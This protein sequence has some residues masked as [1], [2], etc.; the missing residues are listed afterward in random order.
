M[1]NEK[2]GD[3]IRE[4]TVHHSINGDFTIRKGEWK[5]LLSP[6]SGGWSFPKP[7]TDD[8]VIETLPLI[9]LYNMKTD[10]A[11]KNNV[12]AEHPEVVKELKDLMIKYVKEGR[13]TP[14]APQKNDGP[15]VWK[16]LSWME[17]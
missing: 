14:G 9:Q 1:L 13:S 10:P 11:E 6:S 12:Y 17:E 7:G 2:E 15:E 3:V 16:Q 4:A 8:E 5:L